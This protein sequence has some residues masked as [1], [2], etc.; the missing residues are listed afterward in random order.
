VKRG[1]KVGRYELGEEIGEGAM[2]EVF[3][4]RHPLLERRVAI[5]ILKKEVCSDAHY[6]TRFIEDARAAHGLNHPNV[7]RVLDV[8]D[9]AE[10][11]FIVMDLVEG[12]P[13]DRWLSGREVEVVKAVKIARDVA[14]ALAAA[15]AGGL[16]HR[17][18]KPS[19]ILID[20]A[21]SAAKLTDFGAAKRERADGQMLTQMG[22]RIGT[23]RYMAPEQVEG[24]AV[25]TRTDL[26]A[27]GATLYEL[28]AGRPAFE[29]ETVSAVYHG[30][31]LKEPPPLS[32]SRAEIPP[33]LDALVQRLLS[34]AAAGRPG[35]AEEVVA[36]LDEILKEI[37]APT[38]RSSIGVALGGA[39]DAT[40]HGGAATTRTATP[41]ADEVTTTG[42][43]ALA[44]DDET[45][46]TEGG[47]K[48]WVRRQPK[49]LVPVLG[50]VAALV[51]LVVGWGLLGP[52]DEPAESELAAVD[53]N[54]QNDQQAGPA[55]EPVDSTAPAAPEEEPATAAAP[56]GAEEEAPPAGPDA[57]DQAAAPPDQP[58]E[59]PAL[60]EQQ[61]AAPS[62][63]TRLQPE[64]AAPAGD[65]PQAPA[66]AAPPVEPQQ[67][68]AGQP[69][70]E[71][72]ESA[73]AVQAAPG[74]DAAPEAEV[75]Q[76]PPLDEVRPEPN[77]EPAGGQALQT[78]NLDCP[79]GSSACA[80]AQEVLDAAAPPDA[81]PPEVTLNDADGV[82]QDE[83]YLV[84]EVAMPPRLGGYLYLD[85][86]TVDGQAIHLLPEPMR[87]SNDLPEGGI[88]RVGVEEEERASGI[89]F[90]QVSGP[91]G[92]GYL[93]A[94]VSEQP[95]YD[96][97]RQVVEPIDQYRP[98]LLDALGDPATGRKA[99]TVVPLEFRPK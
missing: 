52:A 68:Q 75:A 85:L 53:Q 29:G 13:L 55:D 93:V 61:P 87:E 47:M 35:A 62:D 3:A 57:S 98:M 11:P 74:E 36:Q 63:V 49:W 60:A 21:S 34:K 89:R 65:E 86:F 1:D 42:A 94:L 84:A 25:D 73:P 72:E 9:S 66:S 28:L 23:P 18:V 10:Q 30:I 80:L 71:Q 45:T 40:L 41:R 43:G 91:F 79:A 69:A 15:H 19:N 16:V 59:T 67:P 20:R 50:A 44:G 78:Q 33:A 82:Y 83:Q 64:P 88:I 5:K 14:S 22:Q 31:L 37:A 12:D 39:A 24:S 17:D 56:A 99:A 32:A 97:V 8:D 2:A 26:F 38:T 7:V 70:T 4:S 51:L 77:D 54:D 96:G 95:I 81:D 76:L 27:L 6:V 90:W 46:A 92:T 58:D 48:D